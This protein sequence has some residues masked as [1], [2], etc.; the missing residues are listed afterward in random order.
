MKTD[1]I[2]RAYELRLSLHTWLK[3]NGPA[4]M[5]QIFQAHP[6]IP[7][8]TVR[9]AIY[10]MRQ[11]EN[12]AMHGHRA[13]V[14]GI[15][16]ALSDD[17]RSEAEVRET[18]RECGIKTRANLKT[19]NGEKK[20]QAGE[21]AVAKF[22]KCEAER[23]AILDCLNASSPLGSQRVAELLAMHPDQVLRTIYRMEEEG[24]LVRNGKGRRQTFSAIVLTTVSAE[25]MCARI[26]IRKRET[27]IQTNKNREKVAAIEGYYRHRG[28]DR[29]HP[30][31]NQEA[32]GSGRCQVTISYAGMY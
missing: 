14:A 4:R 12:I 5:E 27:T 21:S 17:I 1:R 30:L 26:E 15:F 16:V 7:H 23:Q 25:E 3:E 8:E 32:Q 19:G 11:T 31:P 24:E 20:K 29:D 2:K 28:M 22:R 18:L 10:A 13:G 9:K 6:D